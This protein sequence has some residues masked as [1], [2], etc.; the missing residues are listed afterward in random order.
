MVRS[1]FATAKTDPQV[2]ALTE[3]ALA[4]L[5]AQGAIVIDSFSLPAWSWEDA[6][7]VKCGGFEYDLNNYFKVHGQT[8]HYKSLQAVIDSGLYLGSIGE[9]LKDAAQAS[10]HEPLITTACLDTY[11]DPMKV[12]FRDA[13]LREMDRQ[14]LDALVYPTWSNPP[15]RV[16]DMKSPGGDNSQVICPMTGFPGITVPMGFTHGDLPA[17]LTFV[18]RSFSEASL[19]R[20]AYAYEQATHHRHAPAA[21]PALN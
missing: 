11:H 7:K 21:F 15:R 20:L 3:K 16:G 2:A 14:K 4:E 10:H 6:D 12:H 13:I 17:G 8:S 19:I 5:K 18:G 9:R 1:Y